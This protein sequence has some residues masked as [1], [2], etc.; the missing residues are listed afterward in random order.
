MKN[1]KSYGFS[2]YRG[3]TGRALRSRPVPIPT[4]ANLLTLPDWAPAAIT[5]MEK[6]IVLIS[7]SSNRIC[8]ETIM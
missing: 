7:P 1:K 6:S 3:S 8:R 4:P 2:T 5:Q